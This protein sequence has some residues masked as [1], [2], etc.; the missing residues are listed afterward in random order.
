MAPITRLIPKLLLEKLPSFKQE[1]VFFTS[2]TEMLKKLIQVLIVTTFSLCLNIQ[3]SLTR[4][5]LPRI[6]LVSLAET[7]F[8]F[9]C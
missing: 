6:A 2:I 7:S 8:A 5:I 3:L 4:V 9:A 1:V